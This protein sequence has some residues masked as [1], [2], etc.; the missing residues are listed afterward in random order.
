MSSRPCATQAGFTLVEILVSLLIFTIVSLAMVGILF[1]AT[2]LF[3]AGESG[4][5]TTDEAVAALGVIDDDLRRM[6][7]GRDGGVFYSALHDPS[8]SETG[9]GDCAVAFEIAQPNP[10]LIQGNQYAAN[11]QAAMVQ[12]VGA[13]L[14]VLY[15]VEPPSS[16]TN[17]PALGTAQ[18]E[19]LL[20]RLQAPILS[21]VQASNQTPNPANNQNWT[22]PPATD[23]QY[24]EQLLNPATRQV[25]QNW[26]SGLPGGGTVVGQ[27]T[28][29]AR[30]AL[31]FGVWV[32]T[33]EDPRGQWG[34]WT[35]DAGTPA[36]AIPP[37][38]TAAYSTQADPTAAIT[39]AAA[40][41][42]TAV[43]FT[44]ALSAGRFAPTGQMIADLG[45]SPDTIR[46]GGIDALPVVPG[47]KILINDEWMQYSGY[48]NGVL[49]LDA[50]APNAGRGALRSTIQQA[51]ARGE[52]VRWGTMFS[53]GR[54]FPH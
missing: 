49:T 54:I 2:N 48:A 25:W 46:I 42:P 12:G 23:V 45:T 17:L 47:A 18:N 53:L 52:V 43:L 22:A 51:H 29:V 33:E 38:A 19:E 36:Q 40:N 34:N 44:L 1:T 16:N 27:P 11:G 8:G 39:T 14:L 31:H 50:N 30:R 4:R 3:K 28:I 26:P 24:I 32:S 5:A 10:M 20:Y 37:T 6:V 41:F 13:R 7:S 15:F 21:D 9:T 35:L